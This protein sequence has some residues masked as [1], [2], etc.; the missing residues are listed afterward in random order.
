[1]RVVGGVLRS[2]NWTR[3]QLDHGGLTH[4]RTIAYLS[5]APQPF[6]KVTFISEQPISSY[7]SMSTRNEQEQWT[8]KHVRDTFL[9]YFKKNGHSFGKRLFDC[10]LILGLI[11]CAVPS[12]SV[13]PLSDPTL[14]FTNAGMNQYK[15][16]FLGTVDP[17]SDF[18]RLKRA[19]NSQKACHRPSYP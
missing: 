19:V 12:S 17:Q 6:A 9:E 3:R 4:A 2:Y 14:L 11:R 8:A 15:S 13:V 7:S 10:K 16:I 5:R 18:A 1:M